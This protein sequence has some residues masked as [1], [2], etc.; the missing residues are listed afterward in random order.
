MTLAIILLFPFV[1]A[2]T[3]LKEDSFISYGSLKNSKGQQISLQ[4]IRS[5]FVT[6]LSYIR[7]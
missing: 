4:D 6:V 2:K 1:L 5:N 3:N 7:L